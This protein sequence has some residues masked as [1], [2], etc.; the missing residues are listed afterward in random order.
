MGEWED[1]MPQRGVDNLRL[2]SYDILVAMI[3]VQTLKVSKWAGRSLR[4]RMGLRLTR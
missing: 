2:D 4:T 3:N 1:D